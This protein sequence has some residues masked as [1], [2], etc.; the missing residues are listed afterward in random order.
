MSQ[1]RF[2][3]ELDRLIHDKKFQEALDR[4]DQAPEEEQGSTRLQYLRID[5]LWGLGRTHEALDACIQQ[6]RVHADRNDFTQAIGFLRKGAEISPDN[7]V[8]ENLVEEFSRR[9]LGIKLTPEV[10]RNCSLFDV[11][12]AE[13]FKFLALRARWRLYMPDQVIIQAGEPSDQ[14]LFILLRGNTEVHYKNDDEEITLAR[15]NPGYVF[16]EVGFL[17]LR[18]RSADVIAR[19]RVEVLEIPGEVMHEVIEREP[20][21]KELLEKL[22][23]HHFQKTLEIL[24]KRRLQ[25]AD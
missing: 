1:D 10:L 15:L 5:C 4:I 18:P 21:V 16:G 23:Q 24:K 2:I 8:L 12:D 20:R 3:E 6:A 7:P 17:T 14:R 19:N 25:A 11:L 22:H 9:T 13:S